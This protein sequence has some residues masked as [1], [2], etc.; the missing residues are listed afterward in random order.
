MCGCMHAK[1]L[2]PGRSTRRCVQ[3]NRIYVIICIYIVVFAFDSVEFSRNSVVEE[4]GRQD[5]QET[6][7]KRDWEVISFNL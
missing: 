1:V 4:F 6:S 3:C 5:V 7:T 2:N